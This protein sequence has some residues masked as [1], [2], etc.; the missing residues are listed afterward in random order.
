MRPRGTHRTALAGFVSGGGTFTMREL[1]SGLGCSIRCAN[2]VI[3]RALQAQELRVVGTKPV[4]GAK[5]PVAEY[6]GASVCTADD[7]TLDRA[8]QAWAR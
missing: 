8:I 5:R 2:D 7:V 3:Y 1:A 4:P 6:A